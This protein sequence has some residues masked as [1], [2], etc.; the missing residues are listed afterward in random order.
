MIEKRK[1]IAILGSTGSIGKQALQVIG[2]HPEYFRA[3][4]LSANGNADMLIK[5]AKKFKP[6]AV[7]I[8]NERLYDQV[9]GALKA[10]GIE[11]YSGYDSISS[12]AEMESIDIVLTAIVGFAGLKPTIRAIES[13]KIIALSNKESLVVAGEY[14]TDLATKTGAHIYPVDSEHSAIFQCIVG[15]LNNKVEKIFLTASGGP[16][17]GKQREELLHV[18]KDLALRHPNWSMGSKVTIDSATLMNK[19]L[20]VI[21]AKWLFGLD[22]GKIEVVIHPQSI[23]HSMVE[24]EDGSVKAQ[25]S[26]PDMRLPIQYAFSYPNRLKTNIP[27]LNFNKEVSLTFKKPDTDTFRNLIL[28]YDALRKCGNMPCILN[29][30]NEVAVEAFLQDRLGFLQISD[31]IETCMAK[32]P[33]IG[34]NR[35]LALK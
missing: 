31:V 24:F 11:V 6:K 18:T 32:M 28:A 20:E 4:V 22:P 7:A 23:V 5:Q 19:G 8:G 12:L 35:W 1:N 16:F 30:A 15:E 10:D 34:A 17:H 26:M 13:G 21:E 29:A 27:R 3:E 33:S 25:L 14:I 9:S 2:A